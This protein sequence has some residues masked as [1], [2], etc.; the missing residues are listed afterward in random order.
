MGAWSFVQPRFRNLVGVNLT[1][2]G[3][4]ELCQ[5]AVGVS[6]VHHKEAAQIIEDTFVV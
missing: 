4:V 1:Y 3:R 5:P 2:V 6:S